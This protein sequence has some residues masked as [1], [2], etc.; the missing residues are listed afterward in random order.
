[1]ASALP[2]MAM[3][4][5]AS[6][7]EVVGCRDRRV[8]VLAGAGSGKTATSV[9]WVA[10]LVKSG[11][12]RKGI[13][14]IT[15]TRKAA[16]EMRSRVEGLLKGR[17]RRGEGD[18]LT[19][20]TYHAVASA[21]MREDAAGFGLRD[22]R[23]TTID[24][25]ESQ[26]VWKS[27]LRECGIQPKSALFAPERLRGAYSFARNTMVP[28]RG[29]LEPMF[30]KHVARLERV[31]AAYERL[32]RAANA[33]DYDDL[34]VLWERRLREDEAFAA[35]QRKRWRYVLVDEMQDNNR[36]NA[37]ILEALAPEHLMVVG[38]VN[39]SIYAFRGSDARLI[40][41]FSARRADTRVLRLEDN[42]RSGQAILDLANAV[43][44][45][46]EAALSLRA[47]NGVRASVRCMVFHDP[48]H[49]ALGVI[50]W[51]QRRVAAGS[52]PCDCAVL[53]RSSKLFT[54]LE[55]ALGRYRIPYRKYGGLTLADA[56]EV[57]DFLAFLRLALNPRDRLAL[58]RCLTQ[59]PGIGEGTAAKAIDAHDGRLEGNHWPAQAE[60]LPMWVR[61][62]RE[63]REIGGKGKYLAEH[64]KPLI[65]T[66]YPKDAPE[67][68]AT[69]GALVQSMASSEGSLAEFLDGFVLDRTTAKEHPEQA[70]TLSTI[71][72]AKGLEWDG[73]WLLGAGSKQLPH[74]RTEEMSTMAEERRLCYV[75]ITRPREDLV[76]SYPG[77]TWQKK[78]QRGCPFFPEDTHWE[79][80]APMSPKMPA[81][82]LANAK[83]AMGSDL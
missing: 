70:I 44:A 56:S 57:K 68:I 52:R 21:L 8:V 37:A 83:M 64:I 80:A 81:A 61:R 62:I 16:E 73:V 67:R 46:S 13:L 33:V 51:V 28:V 65:E 17:P 42:Y 11:V 10:D 20:G 19:V 22:G 58:L 54:A 74:P 78:P 40:T 9:H 31:I 35:A 25:G 79:Y 45:R 39:Q 4:L 29:L 3:K 66:N 1:M 55:I 2:R 5:N 43:V 38:D 72:S 27:A 71:H 14:M 32:K 15:F 7:R 60:A 59:F 18:V 30:P 63:T 82:A 76:I 12:P 49:E 36:L 6:Q 53:T 75:A 26:S 34:L 23:Y 77:L 24:E 69:I 48:D 50:D 41:E 47:A